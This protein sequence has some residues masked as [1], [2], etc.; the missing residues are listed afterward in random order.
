[1]DESTSSVDSKT[2]YAVYQNIFNEWQDKTIIASIHRLNLL[3]LFDEVIVMDQGKIVQMGTVSDLLA[4]KG[5]LKTL[6]TTFQKQQER[7]RED[8]H[9]VS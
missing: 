8:H 3:P 6:W 4:K 7:N 5:M 9:S 2:E 1:M